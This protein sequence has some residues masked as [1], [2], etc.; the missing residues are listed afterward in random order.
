MAALRVAKINRDITGE[1]RGGGRHGR[2]EERLVDTEEK[3]K[4]AGK[5]GKKRRG[6]EK[7]MRVKQKA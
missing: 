3:R 4:R 2:E 1:G 5:N 7:K 6:K